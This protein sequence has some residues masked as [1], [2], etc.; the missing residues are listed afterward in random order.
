MPLAFAAAL[1]AA[2]PVTG[3]SPDA[4]RLIYER[5]EIQGGSRLW[6]S[7]VSG[8]APVP[9]TN[10]ASAT[11]FPGAWSP[12]GNWFVYAAIRNGLW[13]LLKV[14]ATGQATPVLLKHDSHGAEVPVWS[15]GGDWILYGN[16]LYSPDGQKTP[17]LAKHGSP[18]YEFSADGKLLYGIRHD[19]DRNLLF[20]LDAVS[21][22][23]K[24]LG[25]L[26][27]EFAP[28]SSFSPATRLSPAPDGNSFVYS[29]ATRHLQSSGI[30]PPDSTK[31]RVNRRG[32]Y[33][34]SGSSGNHSGFW[35]NT[36][37]ASICRGRRPQRYTS[38]SMCMKGSRCRR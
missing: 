2:A 21:G 3:R 31:P 22:V 18:N 13:D 24:V 4:G 36:G 33:Q 19:G 6:M 27:R 17:S 12:D 37:A 29:V 34:D 10:D 15:P 28:A 35:A 23:E 5:F 25:D 16:D 1:R 30:Q 8:G 11:E 9:L 32:R 20:S 26:G 14:K 7:A 38:L